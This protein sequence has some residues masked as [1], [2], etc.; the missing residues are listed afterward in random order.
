MQKSKDLLTIGKSADYLEVS[1]DTLRRWE[2]KGAVTS[3]RSPGGH[4][5]FAKEDLDKLFGQKYTRVNPAINKLEVDKKQ[6]IDIKEDKE[7]IEKEVNDDILFKETPAAQKETVAE[8][9]QVIQKK[10]SPSVTVQKESPSP[11]VQETQI[12]PPTD[13]NVLIPPTLIQ[14]EPTQNIPNSKPIQQPTQ[15]KKEISWTTII[16]IG[17]ILFAVIDL[18]LL[19]VYLTSDRPLTSPV[20]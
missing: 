13:S 17:L 1:I 19:I 18:V 2:L 15:S 14:K 16:I 9:P 8:N 6:G 10:D 11:I 3:Y 12:N 7:A 4:R 5:Y 20:P